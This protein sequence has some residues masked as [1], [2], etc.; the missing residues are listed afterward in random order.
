MNVNAA[1]QY[2]PSV[3]FRKELVY[4]YPE[5]HLQ[6]VDKIGL[7]ILLLIAVVSIILY[8]IGRAK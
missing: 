5:I 3:P 1:Y 6:L 8:A 7:T 2:C 4:C